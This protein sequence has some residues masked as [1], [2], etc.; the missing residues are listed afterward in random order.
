[1]LC[2]VSKTKCV[3]GEGPHW[4]DVEKAL[5]WVDIEQKFLYRWTALTDQ[6]Q[7]FIPFQASAVLDSRFPKVTLATEIGIVSFDTDSMRYSVTI[8]IEADDPSRRSNEAKCDPNGTVWFSTLERRQ[9]RPTGRLYRVLSSG[10]VAL[11][12]R[13][14]YIPNTLAWS[15]DGS[16]MYFADSK[17]REIYKADYSMNCGD[18]AA[19]TPWIIFHTGPGVPD[20]STVDSAGNLWTAVW[21][22]WRIDCHQPDGQLCSSVKLP[23]QRPTSCTFGGQRRETLYITTA[24]VELDD[25]QL[26]HQPLAGHV[27]AIDLTER[28]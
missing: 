5:Y 16:C 15:P 25:M 28:M 18:A 4:S 3:L 20:G 12:K 8:P 21:D 27:L 7:W 13:D 6:Q 9:E 23:V 19:P 10:Q 14:L 22:G 26:K 2:P 11:W 1:M 17:K 24:T